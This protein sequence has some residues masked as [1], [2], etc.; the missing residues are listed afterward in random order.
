MYYKKMKNLQIINSETLERIT[1]KRTG[2]KKLH[3][4]V[5]YLTSSNNL[6]ERITD[7]QIEFVL[8]GI[9]EDIG[10]LANHGQP[11]ARDTWESVIKSLLNIQ[12]NE[13]TNASSILILGHL[14]F[15]DLY[16]TPSLT[17]SEKSLKTYRKHVELIDQ[18]V[19]QLVYSIVKAGK[20]P[21]VV[22][23][24]HNNAYG[25]IKGC[26][27]GL[28]TKVNAV[29][30]DAHTDLRTLEGRH[31]GNGFSYAIEEGFLDRYFIFGLHENY[32]TKKILKYISTSK[33]KI[34]FISFEDLIVRK[35]TSL[36]RA[37]KNALKFVSKSNFGIEIDCDAI[38]NI[39]S[40]AQTPSGFSVNQTRQFVHYFGKHEKAF[41]LHICEAATVKD[42]RLNEQTGKL[43]SY[44]ITDFISAKKS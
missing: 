38:E 21:I 15:K 16:G 37:S 30:F 34:K 31:S 19:N 33:S 9:K 20:T 44:L 40:S 2:E 36:R 12:S 23:G 13:Y 1:Q 29:N 8:F 26:A 35:E 27:L 41:Y 6:L 3:E 39:P 4:V 43:I 11:G 22:G 18:N 28:K 14:D 25:I 24:G 42:E 5:Q 32:I 17:S 7:P 10:V